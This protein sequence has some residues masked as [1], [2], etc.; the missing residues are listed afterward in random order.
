MRIA[1]ISA[2]IGTNLKYY[3]D[4]H[5]PQILDNKSTIDYFYFDKTNLPLRPNA[6]H[7]RLQ[8]KLPKMFGWE[9]VPGYDYYIWG[10]AP[11]T[12]K[13]PFTVQWL[14]DVCAGGD[15][16]FFRHEA[17]RSSIKEEVD[18]MVN[19]M[20]GDSGDRFAMDYLNSRYAGE[21]FN[22]QLAK[23]L[24]DESFNDSQLFSCSF[25]LYKNTK[26]VQKLLSEWY[27]HNCLY[28]VRCQV[29]F[30]YVLSKSKCRVYT[31]DLNARDNQHITYNW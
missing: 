1:Y 3:Q 15:M 31:I 13:S 29:S 2:N 26:K 14:V 21:N 17:G 24:S 6:L 10:D 27:I 30:P 7:P 5:A 25:F 11:I 4:Q 8:G 16:V 22:A 9:M 12:F 18:F 19:H 20:S 23:Y 28:T